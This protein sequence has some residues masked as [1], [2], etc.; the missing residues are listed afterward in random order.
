M[1][2]HEAT[3]FHDSAHINQHVHAALS[4]TPLILLRE[5]E[6]GLLVPLFN[7]PVGP[8]LLCLRLVHA[9]RCCGLNPP[10]SS[11]FCHTHTQTHTLICPSLPVSSD[12]VKY[13]NVN[14]YNKITRCRLTTGAYREFL[15]LLFAKQM[16][17]AKRCHQIMI[18]KVA[19]ERRSSF[20]KR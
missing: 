8:T 19:V 6:A 18:A 14:K 7:A 3:C 5:G 2:R 4:T 15:E 9:G 20:A 11:T 17:L 1:K 16:C 12:A 13:T 10:L